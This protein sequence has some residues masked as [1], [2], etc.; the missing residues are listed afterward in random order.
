MMR[1]LAKSSFC[2]FATQTLTGHLLRGAVAFALLSL[3]IGHQDSHPAGS[4]LAGVLALA[5]IRGCP[6]CWTSWRAASARS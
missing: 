4:L 5:A 2:V 3:A 6:M 1:F